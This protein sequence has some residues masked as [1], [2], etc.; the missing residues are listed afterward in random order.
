SASLMARARNPVRACPG[1][2][3]QQPPRT[4]CPVSDA[5]P[6]L[7][8]NVWVNGRRIRMVVPNE[9]AVARQHGVL[10]GLSPASMTVLSEIKPEHIAEITYVDQFDTSIGKLGAQGGLFVVLKP[11]VV[12]EEGKGT[13][14]VAGSDG[15]PP[16]AQPAE[17]PAYRYRLLGVFDAETGE[18][19]A[20]ADVVDMTTGTRARTTVTGTVSLVFLPEGG[21]PVRIVKP[22]Y[23]DLTLAVEISA[24]HRDP[25]TLIMTKAAPPAPKPPAR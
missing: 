11:G 16:P 18:P 1:L 21:T 17:L 4:R 2:V 19:I 15:A 8:T 6:S 7:E 22:G 23:E 9:M 25:L 14:V 20:G 5:P 13:L 24:E 3:F 10:A 12:Y